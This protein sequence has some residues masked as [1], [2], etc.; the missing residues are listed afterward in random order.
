MTNHIANQKKI[1]E[2][3]SNREFA[4]FFKEGRPRYAIRNNGGGYYTSLREIKGGWEEAENQMYTW[5]IWNADFQGFDNL[6][7]FL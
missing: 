7:S 4:I 2:T 6:D 1:N 3:L 5:C